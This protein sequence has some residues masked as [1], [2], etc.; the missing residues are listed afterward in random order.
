MNIERTKEILEINSVLKMW[1]QKLKILK[2]GWGNTTPPKIKKLKILENSGRNLGS[3]TSAL[4]G[5]QKE[6]IEENGDKEWNEYFKIISQTEVYDFLK[7]PTWC[8]VESMKIL[9]YISV[10]FQETEDKKKILKIS[11]NTKIITAKNL[12]SEWILTSQ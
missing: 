1:W 4:W 3:S 7:R 9:R 2:M 8:L 6:R 5:L 12:E 11:R 10:H